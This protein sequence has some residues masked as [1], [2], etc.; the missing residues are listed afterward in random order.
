VTELAVCAAATETSAPHPAASIET[1]T[2]ILALK[3]RPHSIV[4]TP[5]SRL[6][7]MTAER[8][9]RANTRAGISKGAGL[10]I[11]IISI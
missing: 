9:Q 8:S 3:R 7:L 11:A 4:M 5:H 6:N 1:D 10:K 2:N